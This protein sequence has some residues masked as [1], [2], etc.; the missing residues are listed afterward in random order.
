MLLQSL[1]QMSQ[2]PPEALRQLV[3]NN[4]AQTGGEGLEVQ[5]FTPYAVMQ[6]LIEYFLC[7]CNFKDK[8]I[9]SEPQGQ[10]ILLC[11]SFHLL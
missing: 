7:F 8:M 11:K 1:I 4:W 10:D 2:E 6:G 9:T 3:G 5:I